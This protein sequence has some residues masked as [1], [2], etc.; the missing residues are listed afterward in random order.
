VTWSRCDLVHERRFRMGG[1]RWALPLRVVASTPELHALHVAPGTTFM[2]AV[3]AGGR[4]HRK[5]AAAARVG[6]VDAA[7]A[8]AE[9]ER[10]IAEWPFP[11]GWE[12]FRP[13]PA[14]QLPR[15][16]EGYDR[17]GAPPSSA[18]R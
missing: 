9:G 1:L 8:R 18:S 12:D 4:V 15:L 17:D 5:L 14:W 16:P 11:T 10:V 2:R 7:A 3:A 6:R 13:D